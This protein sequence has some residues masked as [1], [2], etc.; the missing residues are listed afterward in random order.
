MLVCTHQK[1]S[2]LLNVSLSVF[3]RSTLENVDSHKILDLI[4][5][6]YLTWKTHIEHIHSD[7]CKL[8]GLLWRCRF[9]LPYSSK[10]LFYHSYIAPKIDYCL[11]L[12]GKA[13]HNLLSKIWRLQKEQYIYIYKYCIFMKSVF[14]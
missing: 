9:K 8:I 7:L 6:K 14:I 5:D 13:S 10:L 12:W 4:I 11:P 2:T 1:R 3:V